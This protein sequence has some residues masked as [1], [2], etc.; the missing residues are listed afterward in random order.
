M[1]CSRPV[2]DG[3]ASPFRRRQPGPG[4]NGEMGREGVGRH[5]HGRG[6]VAGREAVR[7]MAHKQL[8]D[9]QPRDL[10]EGRKGVEGFR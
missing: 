5:A 1:D 10:G 3:T 6:D 9:L 2:D 4:Q 7:L 8:E